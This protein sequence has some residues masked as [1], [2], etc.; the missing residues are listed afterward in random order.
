MV[1]EEDTAGRE[2]PEWGQEI[3]TRFRG[4]ALLYKLSTFCVPEK[5]DKFY[6]FK[7]DNNVKEV[8]EVNPQRHR[9][10]SKDA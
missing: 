7:K 8:R 9:V 4:E 2:R 5:D 3:H 10:V 6:G 1:R